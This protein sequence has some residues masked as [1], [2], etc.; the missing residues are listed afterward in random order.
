MSALSLSRCFGNPSLEYIVAILL[1]GE[2]RSQESIVKPASSDFGTLRVRMHCRDVTTLPPLCELI[3]CYAAPNLDSL[4]NML[5]FPML[6]YLRRH[7]PQLDSSCLC[8]PVYSD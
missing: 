7:P 8:Y 2:I 3:T 6:K 4:P 5:P 1:A